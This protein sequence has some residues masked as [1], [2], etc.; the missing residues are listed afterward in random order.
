MSSCEH[1]DGKG[2]ARQEPDEREELYAVLATEDR[3]GGDAPVS[4]ERGEESA[5]CLY[6][7]TIDSSKRWRR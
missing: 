3:E 5:M 7:R 2:K 1:Q 6:L 4:S